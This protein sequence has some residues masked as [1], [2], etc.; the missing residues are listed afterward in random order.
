MAYEYLDPGFLQML[1]AGTPAL[2][3]FAL[4]CLKVERISMGVAGF[5][6]I[7]V[8]GSVL[9]ACHTPHINLVGVSIQLCSQLCEVL[10]CV[11][12]QIFLQKLS[13]TALDA[14]Y[15]IAPTTAT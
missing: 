6:L 7:M 13:F 1:K 10:Q 12:T 2:L 5:A 9:A 8:F 15:Y 3:L 4:I 11:T 14:G